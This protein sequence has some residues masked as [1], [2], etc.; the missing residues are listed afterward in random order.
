MKEKE[1]KP[2]YKTKLFKI[3][4]SKHLTREEFEKEVNNET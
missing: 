2:E 3:M 4:K 1:L